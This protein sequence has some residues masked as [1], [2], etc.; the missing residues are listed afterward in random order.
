M[1]LFSAW[2]MEDA[3]SKHC[4]G[5]DHAARSAASASYGDLSAHQAGEEEVAGGFE[6]SVLK[7]E[8]TELA[9]NRVY[10]G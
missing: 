4:S 5:S 7:A 1:F 3:T 6:V 10:S 2:C 8:R 9:D